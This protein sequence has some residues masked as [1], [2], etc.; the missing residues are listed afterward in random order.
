MFCYQCEQTA[1]GTGCTVQG[2]C[3]KQP[4][5]AAL[6]DLLLYS[7]MGL[8]RVAV[9]GRKVGVSD[10]DVNVFTVKAAFS[11]LTNV[12]FDG[13]RFFD[14][15]HQTVVLREKLKA[16]VKNAGGVSTWHE[17]AATLTPAE[18][19]ADLVAQGEQVGLTSYP[20]DSA[21][22]LSLK[23]TVLFGIKGVSAYAD[24][25]LILGQ[26]DESVYAYVQEGLA[27]I[28]SD[29][30]GLEL[31]GDDLD[32]AR[33][34]AV[35][36]GLQRFRRRQVVDATVARIVRRMAFVVRLQG[37]RRDVVTPAPDVDLLVA[38]LRGRL[39]L[40]E[41]LQRAVVALVEAPVTDDRDPHAVHLV[42]HDPQRPDGTLQ[43]RGVRDIE[44]DAEVPELSPRGRG[45][46]DAL[47][48]Q[49]DVRPA[50]E[51]IP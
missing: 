15:I 7:L 22:I 36:S 30:L 1:K 20:A 16:Q 51:K 34:D 26:E 14:L 28:Q 17:G 33:P 27:A 32:P 11:T 44:F 43:D 46:V 4:D 38:V 23:H 42:E 6:Q 47:V 19:M 2:V 25:A 13:E 10:R 49:V 24:H 45:L 41:A 12:D 9:E 48:R 39:R 29:D 40:V 37:R 8:S 3:G 21:D 18:T 35:E 31:G 50:G 5:I